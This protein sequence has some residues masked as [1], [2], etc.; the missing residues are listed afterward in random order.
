MSQRLRLAGRWILASYFVVG[1]IGHFVLTR[2]FVM[3]VPPALPAPELLVYVSGVF[4]LLGAA[5]ILWPP[6]MRFSGWGLIALMVCVLPANVF[7]A[8]HPEGFSQFSP[9]TLWARVPAQGLLAALAI[10]SCTLLP[11]RTK[12]G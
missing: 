5:G 4:E 8:M 6:T 3:I 11:P 1:G 12:P 2:F 9:L 7:M 10:W